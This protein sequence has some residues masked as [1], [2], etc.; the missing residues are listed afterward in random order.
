MTG[1]LPQPAQPDEDPGA[2]GHGLGAAGRGM[3]GDKPRGGGCTER[4][5]E[6]ESRPLPSASASLGTGEHVRTP[7]DHLPSLQTPCLHLPQP[8]GW[9]APARLEVRV[10][11]S[12]L[13]EVKATLFSAAP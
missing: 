10:T 5:M 12:Q 9:L 4:G 3:A 11:A 1:G 13:S 2:A 7:P 6:G 8:A